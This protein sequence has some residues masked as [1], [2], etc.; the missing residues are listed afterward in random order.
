MSRYVTRAQRPLFVETP[1]W[2][3]Q[4]ASLTPDLCVEGAKEVDTGLVS[5]SGD[6]IYRIAPPIGFGRN[7]EW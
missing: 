7:E 6:P 2:D 4:R 1:R 3:D 5:L